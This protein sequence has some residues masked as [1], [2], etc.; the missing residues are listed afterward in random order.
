MDAIATKKKNAGND[1]LY[2][3]NAVTMVGRSAL[4]KEQDRKGREGR[5]IES[6]V[7]E[8]S[9]PSKCAS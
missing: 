2:T 9:V 7:C 1:L 8:M 3:A 4:T 6:R 5:R